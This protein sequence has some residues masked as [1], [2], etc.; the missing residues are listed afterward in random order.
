MCFE[1][2]ELKSK[3]L[4]VENWFSK[5][6]LNI[7]WFSSKY[8]TQCI[9]YG[10]IELVPLKSAIIYI[11]TLI[12]SLFFQKPESVKFCWVFF[13]RIQLLIFAGFSG[14]FCSD[15]RS[16]CRWFSDP[17]PCI[18]DFTKKNALN[19]SKIPIFGRSHLQMF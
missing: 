9:N 11:F 7:K 12:Y 13:I 15:F 18:V 1:I 6:M 4:V 8:L 16:W 5:E 19:D 10:T 3:L 2:K 14:V 17:S